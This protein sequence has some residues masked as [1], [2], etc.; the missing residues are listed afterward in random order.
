MGKEPISRKKNK[1]KV[2]ALGACLGNI[3]EA[4]VAGTKRVMGDDGELGQRGTED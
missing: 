2:H 3:K 1:C 4:G